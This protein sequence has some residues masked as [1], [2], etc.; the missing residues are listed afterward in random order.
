MG[1]SFDDTEVQ[2]ERAALDAI[3]EEYAKPILYGVVA[4][5]DGYEELLSRMK[6]AG[7]QKYFD[8]FQRQ[9]TEWYENR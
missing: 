4:Y 3:V 1:F 5:E 7:F 8:E 9:F 6:E 2:V